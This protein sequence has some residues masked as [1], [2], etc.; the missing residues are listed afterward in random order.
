VSRIP[1]ADRPRSLT[2]AP[3][4]VLL[5]TSMLCARSAGRERGTQAAWPAYG[6]GS[7]TLKFLS[8]RAQDYIAGSSPPDSSGAWAGTRRRK[9]I[10]DG[11]PNLLGGPQ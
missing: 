5:K 4:P 10:S 1:S 2:L 9:V 3:A 7:I 8:V 11:T 6:D